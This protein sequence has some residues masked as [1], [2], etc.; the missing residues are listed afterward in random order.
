MTE[1]QIKSCCKLIVN[2]SKY[3]L[4]DYHKSLIKQLIDN[5]KTPQE[6]IA[7]VLNILINTK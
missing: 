6:L 2:N 4:S 5:A 1:E 3:P 7:G